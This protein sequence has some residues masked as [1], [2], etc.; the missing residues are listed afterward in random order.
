M[1]W[2]RLPVQCLRQPT[3]ALSPLTVPSLATVHAFSAALTNASNIKLF[4][5]SDCP[6]LPTA[7]QTSCKA[8]L[9]AT[10]LKLTTLTYAS[11]QWPHPFTF[12][13]SLC[14]PP[15]CPVSIRPH[16]SLF[17][18]HHH[19]PQTILTLK[20]D[21]LNFSVVTYHCCTAATCCHADHFKKKLLNLSSAQVDHLNIF[22]FKIQYWDLSLQACQAQ[23]MAIIFKCVPIIPNTTRSSTCISAGTGVPFISQSGITRQA[24][25]VRQSMLFSLILCNVF[26]AW[27]STLALPLINK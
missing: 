12:S 22:L 6:L 24:S 9:L 21:I 5:L 15:C 16:T 10:L 19:C 3:Y 27:L 14:P 4:S 2:L 11:H 20:C 7:V 23:S 18:G 17:C 26:L 25:Q 8:T 13:L 1:N